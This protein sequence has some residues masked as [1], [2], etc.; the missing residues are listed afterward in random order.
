[1]RDEELLN[2]ANDAEEEAS[3][4]FIRRRRRMEDF[5][6]DETQNAYWDTTTGQLLIANA[7]NG[8]IPREFW[9][10]RPDGR[11]G[12]LRPFEPALAINDVDTGLTVEGSTWWPG[13]PKFIENAIV[14]ARGVIHTKGA[15]SYNTYVAPDLS[16]LRTDRNPDRWIEHIKFL[17][18]DPVEHEHFFNF[19]AHM[20]QRAD[21]KVNHGIVIAGAQGIGKDTALLPLRRAVGEWNT[22]EISPDDIASPYNPYIKSVMLVINEVR[23]HDEDH[24]ASNFYNQ[25][26][27]LLAAPP[28]M[29]GMNVKY[30]NTIYVRNLCHVILT[31]NDPL[32]M[33]IPNEDRRLFVM[34]SPVPD[35]KKTPIFA[36]GYFDE[37]HSWMEDGGADSVAKWLANR[38]IMQ[39]NP[40]S[41]PPMTAGKLAII[42][43]THEVRRSAV[44]DVFELYTERFLNSK[45]PDV[46]FAKDLIDFVTHDAFFDDKE[47]ILKTLTAKSFHFKMDERGYVMVKNPYA[48]E[49]RSGKFRSRAAFVRKEVAAGDRL[50]A[51]SAELEKRPLDFKRA[52][53]F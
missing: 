21:E 42:G 28:E 40:G 18:P 15:V 3:Q 46:V 14:T 22:A 23:P 13:Q 16:R 41:P 38:D 27:P 35:P 30:Q 5:R 39:F 50:E 1:M 43:S 48:S 33:Y 51:I 24:K 26:K 31:T 29:L 8:A 52:E 32:T 9:P 37:M 45:M 44:D 53:S 25:L 47:R 11:N 49:W 17:F 36:P 12:R 2:L 10:T 19:A 34:W 4:L 20:V 6:Y 7:V